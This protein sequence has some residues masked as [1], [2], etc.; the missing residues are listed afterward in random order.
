M[1][2]SQV[3]GAFRG[4]SPR[5]RGHTHRIHLPSMTRM[6]ACLSWSRFWKGSDDG[7]LVV[8]EGVGGWAKRGCGDT[9]NAARDDANYGVVTPHAAVRS[10]VTSLFDLSRSRPL[11]V[12]NNTP[13]LA[14]KL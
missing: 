8:L 3:T 6:K 11:C 10:L 4:L 9:P 2:V 12:H 14:C 7:R 13:S 1:R 5:V